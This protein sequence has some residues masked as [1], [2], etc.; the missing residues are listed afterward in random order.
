VLDRLHNGDA[1]AFDFAFSLV[2][3][4]GTSRTT[5][6]RFVISY[7]LWEERFSVTRLA[8]EGVSEVSA[9]HLGRESAE[10]WCL[11]NI[12]LSASGVR[13]DRTFRARLLLRAERPGETGPLVGDNGISLGAIVD[14]LSR[15]NRAEQ[16][17]WSL[18][19]PPFRLGD[20]R[21][22]EPE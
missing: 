6:A 13:E 4:G 12:S 21:P 17:T 15:R 3:E 20:A 1:A 10:A 2:S 5:G 14:L 16:Q 18:E 8:R 22:K 19:S 11:E 9:S 7:D